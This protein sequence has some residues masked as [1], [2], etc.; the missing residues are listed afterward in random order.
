MLQLFRDVPMELAER[1][2]STH[3][4]EVQALVVYGSVARGQ[5]QWSRDVDRRSDIDLLVVTQKPNR[6]AE[7]ILA[8]Q[9]EVDLEWGT[10]TNIIYRTP[11]EIREHYLWGDSLIVNILKEGEVLYDSGVFTRIRERLNG[12]GQEI[13]R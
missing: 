5:A 3:K 2:L 8:I 11:G 6:I 4:N 13:S 1:I 10:I 12:K 9:T 7:A